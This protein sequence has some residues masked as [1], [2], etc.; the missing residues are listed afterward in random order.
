MGLSGLFW[1]VAIFSTLVNALMLIA[2]LYM[3][4]VYDRVIPSRSKETL[5]AL[6]VLI[7]LL[8]VVMGVLD[9]VRGRVAARIGTIFQDRLDARVFRAKSPACRR[10]VRTLQARFGSEGRRGCAAARGLARA[11]CGL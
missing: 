10:F 8:F 3:L 5:L 11:L 9:Y 7:T 2:P 6:T 1:S 4:Q